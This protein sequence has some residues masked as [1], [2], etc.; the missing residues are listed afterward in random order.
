M[1]TYKEKFSGICQQI[2]DFGLSKQEERAK[3]VNTFLECLNDAKVEN[4][5]QATRSIEEFIEYKK[6]VRYNFSFYL[7]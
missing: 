2:F 1:Y 7:A 5:V 6:K 4:K 3:E